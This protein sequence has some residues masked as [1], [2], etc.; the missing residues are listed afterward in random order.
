[1]HTEDLA[2]NHHGQ[3]EEVEHVG[4]VCPHEGRAVLALALR[5]E[6]VRLRTDEWP[7]R[8]GEN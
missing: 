6:A 3:R 5:V 1:M 8:S 4:E 2:V 7:G